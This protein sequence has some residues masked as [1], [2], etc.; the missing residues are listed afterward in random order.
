M[1]SVERIVRARED[2]ETVLAL[3]DRQQRPGASL[4]ASLEPLRE[5]AKDLRDGLDELERRFRTPPRTKG[6]VYDD[7]KV[8]NK[9]GLAMGYVASAGGEP[10]PTANVYVEQARSALLDAE[11]ELDRYFET[12]VAAFS[13]AVAAAG[14]GL[15]GHPGTR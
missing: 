2:V 7:D 4:P 5:Q 9:V 3:L 6:I 12:E 11:A 13:R 10:S 14:I 8:L 15:F 1:T